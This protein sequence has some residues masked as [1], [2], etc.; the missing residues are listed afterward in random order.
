M[1]EIDDLRR[2]VDNLE[3]QLAKY[4]EHLEESLNHNSEFQLSASWG[5]VKSINFAIGAAGS[6]ALI[7]YGWRWLGNEAFWVVDVA[8][9]IV[10]IGVGGWAS[11]RAEKGQKDDLKKLYRWPIW[12]QQ[13]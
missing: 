6:F 10:A 1:S 13:K 9:W 11:L 7:A 2:R 3:W 5:V 12:T 8:A 4:H